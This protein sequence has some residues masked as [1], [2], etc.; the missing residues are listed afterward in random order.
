MDGTGWYGDCW[1]RATAETLRLIE[2]DKKTAR[3]A[4]RSIL[5]KLPGLLW[6]GDAAMLE[7][8]GLARGEVEAHFHA[9]TNQSLAEYVRKAFFELALWFLFHTET[10][11]TVVGEL[12]GFSSH[13]QFYRTVKRLL[14]VTAQEL[15]TR[16]RAVRELTTSI[17]GLSLH[18]RN[19]WRG[20]R[21]GSLERRQVETIWDFFRRLYPEAAREWRRGRELRPLSGFGSRFQVN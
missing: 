11:T 21:D 8:S 10:S 13:Q 18:S 16:V 19:T 2:R 12:T 3:P 6:E 17:D 14:G 9:D 4:V 7:E 1:R 20:L 15:E 5:D